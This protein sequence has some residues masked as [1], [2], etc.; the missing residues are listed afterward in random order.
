MELCLHFFIH[1][2]GVVCLIKHWIRLNG[3][4]LSY[5]QG[6][7]YLYHI[8]NQK[9]VSRCAENVMEIKK[10]N[11]GVKYKQIFVNLCVRLG[12]VMSC[13]GTEM[14]GKIVIYWF[15]IYGVK[16]FQIDGNKT[17]L[18]SEDEHKNSESFGLPV[19]SIIFFFNWLLQSLSDLGLPQWTSRSTL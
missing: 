11:R 19:Y 12:Y 4:V 9:L 1:L 10:L 8:F 2:H 6:Q 14:R 5:V 13:L 15:Q 3:V 17:K 16:I 18:H 7:R